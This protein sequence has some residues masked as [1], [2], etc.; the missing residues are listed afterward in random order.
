MTSKRPSDTPSEVPNIDE[1]NLSNI[2]E[3][4]LSITHSFIEHIVDHR[5]IVYSPDTRINFAHLSK[6]YSTMIEVISDEGKIDDRGLGYL[7]QQME[8]YTK[9]LVQ[10]KDTRSVPYINEIIAIL[11][12][13][14]IV[15][16]KYIMKTAVIRMNKDTVLKHLDNLTKIGLIRR[17]SSDPL[18][19]SVQGS[20]V[21]HFDTLLYGYPGLP[22]SAY[23]EIIQFYQDLTTRGRKRKRYYTAINAE[24]SLDYKQEKGVRLREN[25]EA[26]RGD[27]MIDN[28][29]PTTK[30][31]IELTRKIKS[32]EKWL[33]TDK[34]SMSPKLV[35][36]KTNQFQSEL[37][38]YRKELEKLNHK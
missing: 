18:C 24:S 12:L 27:N 2:D 23:D 34:S 26:N 38:K 11:D 15:S 16:A 4:N 17:Y 28:I 33:D 3:S 25:I 13:G 37:E 21:P 29:D 35:D 19:K 31:I 1:S 14:F 8:H 32:R 10:L 20:L 30:R 7:V 36:Q 9:L 5:L 22:I 6:I